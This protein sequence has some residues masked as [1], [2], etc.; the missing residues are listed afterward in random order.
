MLT[1]QAAGN[2]NTDEQL[3]LHNIVTFNGNLDGFLQLH[4]FFF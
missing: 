1:I 4:K 2:Y 3:R